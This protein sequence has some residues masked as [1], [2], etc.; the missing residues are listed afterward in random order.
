MGTGSCNQSELEVAGGGAS[1]GGKQ[2]DLLYTSGITLS[3]LQFVQSAVMAIDRS[4]EL[5]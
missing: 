1:E 4:I 3:L 5:Q 2:C